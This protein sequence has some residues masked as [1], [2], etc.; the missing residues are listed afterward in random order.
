MEVLVS[1][2]E[3][4]SFS[5]FLGNF[6]IVLFPKIRPEALIKKFIKNIEIVLFFGVLAI[7]LKGSH[8]FVTRYLKIRTSEFSEIWQLDG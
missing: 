6:K 8:S 2:V 4:M 3:K 5:L 7:R 1:E